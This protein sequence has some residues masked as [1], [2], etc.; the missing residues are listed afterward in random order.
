MKKSTL[1]TLLLISVNIVYSQVESDFE[2]FK[3]EQEKEIVEIYRNG[4]RN[5]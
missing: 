5:Q 2:K 1:L 4:S 3:K